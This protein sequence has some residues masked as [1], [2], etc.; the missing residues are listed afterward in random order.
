MTY[1]FQN[2]KT[3]L[4]APVT[5]DHFF[6]IRVKCTLDLFTCKILEFWLE[7]AINHFQCHHLK[8]NPVKLFVFKR[9]LL[10]QFQVVSRKWLL[11]KQFLLVGKKILV[12]L[13]FFKSFTPFV[14]SPFFIL[15]LYH[16][17]PEAFLRFLQWTKISLHW[18]RIAIGKIADLLHQGD[19]FSLRKNF[20]LDICRWEFDWLLPLFNVL[21]FYWVLRLSNHTFRLDRV[22]HSVFSSITVPD[23]FIE[24][25]FL[26]NALLANLAGNK[27]RG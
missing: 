14:T 11:A 12:D 25:K 26:H 18:H 5:F 16:F 10:H 8:N 15:A 19:K 9:P 17:Y 3:A 21:I 20:K 2:N 23:S 4:A 24:W 1:V 6:A 13:K 7:A 27:R 22:C